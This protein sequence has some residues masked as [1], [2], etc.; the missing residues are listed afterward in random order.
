L[1]Q[2]R[3]R[4]VL[5]VG[6]MAMALVLLVGSALMIRTFIAL[7][8]VDPGF[9]PHDVL[10]MQMSTMGQ[11]FEKTAGVAQV[12]R[13]GVQRIN[14]VPGVVNSATSCS[15]PLE[16]GFDLPF[17]I[18]GRPLGDKP[19]HGDAAWTD[20]SPGYFD[21][22]EI[23]VLRGRAFTE[24]D[25]AA[26]ARVVIINQTMAR[27]FW[28]KGDPIGERLII[29]HLIGPE[30]EEGERQIVGIVGDV[31]ADGLD[32]NPAPAVYVPQAQVNDG[33]T[34]LNARIGPLVWMV[35]TRV[36]PH[37]L[38]GALK[39]AIRQ[40][41][42]G[43]PVAE[44]R[45][46]DEVRIASTR[47]SDFNMLLLTIFAGSALL[48]AAIGIYALMAYSV[49]QRTQEIGIRMALGAE[50]SLVRNMVVFQGMKL[51]LMG[52][53][54]G[55]AAGFALTRLMASFLFGVK[56]WDPVAF[57]SVPVLLSLVA[58]MA[59]WLPARRATRV[60]PVN[61]LRYE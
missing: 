33:V 53:G 6:E 56:T 19:A 35:R 57:T 50:R 39:E 29:G 44:V 38:D 51:A 11:R 46:M 59:V 27:Q 31:R 49:A 43:L 8:H 12:V 5:V 3:A 60:D 13:E 4:S 9:N 26:G 47:R 40:S 17:I 61:A 1:G 58:L 24:H 18:A 2:N 28:P 23:P 21:V 42:G 52:V 10:T 45:S 54:I 32:S 15:I 34:A 41:S 36:A 16:G 37:T 22:L 48:L 25:D 7:R 55:L 30:F 20:V 14:A